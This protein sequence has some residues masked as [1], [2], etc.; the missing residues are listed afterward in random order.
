MMAQTEV[1]REKHIQR[2]IEATNDLW[3][4]EGSPCRKCHE[5]NWEEGEEGEGGALNCLLC[6]C[7]RYDQEDCGGEYV[8]RFVKDADG[9]EYWVKDCS[10]CDIPHRPEIVRAYLLGLWG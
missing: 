6:F 3:K 8:M 9:D 2:L 1:Y 10:A 7:P 4:Q 5:M